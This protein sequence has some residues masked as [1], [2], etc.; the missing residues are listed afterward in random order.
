VKEPILAAIG[1]GIPIHEARGH[2]I[3]DIAAAYDR[4]RGDLA[5]RHCR[6]HFVKCAGMRSIVPFPITSEKSE[7]CD[8]RENGKRK[9]K[10]QIGSAVPSK[11]N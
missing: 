11:T 2:M 5:R 10:I 7:S 6:V 1:A 3:V 9:I 8:R 4:R